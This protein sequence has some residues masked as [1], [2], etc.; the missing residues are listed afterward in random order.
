MA[1]II[2]VAKQA[3]VSIATVSRVVNN[4]G[5]VNALTREKVLKSIEALGYVPSELARSMLKKQTKLIAMIVPGIY[6]LFFAEIA[7]YVEQALDEQ[8]YK[9]LI[10]NSSSHSG[11]EVEYIEML[12]QNK[13]DGIII[14][15]DNEIEDLIEDK[16]PIVSF[17]RRFKHTPYVASDNFEGG[18]L[19]AKTLHESGAKYLLYLGDDSF[20]TQGHLATEV[21]KRKSGFL[22]FCQ[23]HGIS[24]HMIEFP[25]HTPIDNTIKSILKSQK[26]DGI[27]AISDFLAAKI[28]REANQMNISIPESLKVIGYDGMD[29]PLNIGLKITSIYQDRKQIA[30][31]LVQTLFNRFKGEEQ[32]AHIMPVSLRKGQT[33]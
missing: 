11:L 19:A 10:S 31:L 27:F 23:E 15:S 24:H 22:S 33:T 8:G 14:I 12:K 32:N 26:Y 1:S 9:M 2:D 6:N 7:H 29:D 20:V 13:V 17:D 3:G 25:K 21:S 4:S 28:I 5:Y 18:K 30:K 16:L